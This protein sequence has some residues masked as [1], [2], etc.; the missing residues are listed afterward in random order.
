MAKEKI[1]F[2][3]NFSRRDA[4]VRFLCVSAGQI[5]FKP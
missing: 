3:N 4:E 1:S 2:K 5:V